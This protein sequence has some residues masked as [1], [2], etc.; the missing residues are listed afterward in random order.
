M[1]RY[2]LAFLLCLA[3]FAARAG[4]IQ[5]AEIETVIHDLTEPL[6]DASGMPIEDVKIYIVNAPEINAYVAGGNNIFINTGLITLSDE[7]DMLVGVVAH[8]L[9]HINGG[10]LLKTGDELLRAN[11][12]NTLGYI[13]GIGAAALGS[14]EAAQAIITGGSHVATR[15]LLKYTRQN[16]DAADQFAIDVM[17]K[18]PYTASGLLD[19]L[20][21][22][23]RMEST[24]YGKIN[25]YTSTH[26]LTRDRIEHIRS[27]LNKSKKKSRFTEEQVRRFKRS[28]IKLAAFL[29]PPDET[30]KRFPASD[31][32]LYARYGRAIAYYRIPNLIK[33]FNNLD[34]LIKQYPNDPYFQELKGQ[35]LFENGRVEEAV[36]FYKNADRLL[37]NEPQI[38][39]QLARAEIAVENPKLLPSAIDHL[40][41]VVAKDSENSF[42]WHQLGIA[43]GRNGQ[44]GLSNLALAEESVLQKKKDDAKHFLNQAKGQL[45]EG[46]PAMMRTL[47]LEVQADR[48]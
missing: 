7:P 2:L 15:Q 25:P 5:D 37:P 41:A 9:G 10:H 40:K 48:L 36:D 33:S 28:S 43:Y 6:F 8:E 14:P 19:L 29:S 1:L 13:L 11:I 39:I 34:S 47:D 20:E 42:A 4:I 22:L 27:Y 45:K 31:T 46:S 24:R 23:M 3:P 30:L 26:P 35:I 21:Y 17:A 16:E 18:T 32:S 38:L 12:K 44:L